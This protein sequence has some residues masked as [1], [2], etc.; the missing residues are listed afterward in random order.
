MWTI[1][2]SAAATRASN[3]VTISYRD[4]FFWIND[5][6]SVDYKLASGSGQA[7]LNTT[8]RKLSPLRHA[9]QTGFTSAM[10]FKFDH[11]IATAPVATR[12]A[13]IAEKF[14]TENKNRRII[15]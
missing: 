1:E 10:N 2:S 5:E 8:S 4:C 12:S 15:F 7:S 14:F 13:R 9:S 6:F 3:D 11:L